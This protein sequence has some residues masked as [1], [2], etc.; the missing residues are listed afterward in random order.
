MVAAHSCDSLARFTRAILRSASASSSWCGL[1]RRPG[2]HARGSTGLAPRHHVR[3]PWDLPR[4]DNTL[5]LSLA[6][7]DERYLA[8]SPAV[9]KVFLEVSDP[10]THFFSRSPLVPPSCKYSTYS[11]N[12]GRCCE[13]YGPLG[14]CEWYSLP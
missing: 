7:N 8:F 10:C 3:C 4:L 12:Q 13:L 11:T 9:T 2:R 5:T 6:R 1:T 14:R